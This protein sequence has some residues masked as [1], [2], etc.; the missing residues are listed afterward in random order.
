MLLLSF[1]ENKKRNVTFLE[2]IVNFSIFTLICCSRNSF[3]VRYIS[4][5]KYCC[6]LFVMIVILHWSYSLLL[7]RFFNSII[8]GW[9]CMG[10]WFINCVL[11]MIHDFIRVSF[12]YSFMHCTKHWFVH[13]FN[14]CNF[15]SGDFLPS[16]VCLLISLI[17]IS[18]E[19]TY[20]AVCP[21]S[22]YWLICYSHIFWNLFNFEQ[23]M[24]G[25]V[26]KSSSF[27]YYGSDLLSIFVLWRKRLYIM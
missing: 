9:M 23:T 14:L 1:L 27:W 24:F 7:E 20:A 6:I 10:T 4:V 5:C 26:P 16:W 12:H 2:Y 19:Q 22:M 17:F 3:E 15:L 18:L 21:I 13:F 11:E 8:I 25:N